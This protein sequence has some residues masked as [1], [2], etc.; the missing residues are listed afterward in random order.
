[1]Q[2]SPLRPT[3]PRR[4][5]MLDCHVADVRTYSLLARALGAVLSVC[6]VIVPS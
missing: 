1:M 2:I 5:E 4:A 3:N 6:M